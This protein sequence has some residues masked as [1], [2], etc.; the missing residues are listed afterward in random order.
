MENN[1]CGIYR[2]QNYPKINKSNNRC[3]KTKTLALPISGAKFTNQ[4]A[5][6]MTLIKL[7]YM[8]DIIMG[9]SGG[10]VTGAILLAAGI[11]NVK[12]KESYRAFKIK[13]MEI[14][15][16]LD[17]SWYMSHWSTLAPIN[18]IEALR[19]GS[20]YNRGNGSLFVRNMYIDISSQ[21]ELWIGTTI[22]LSRISQ[23]FC[24]KPKH[25]SK[26]KIEGAKYMENN[27]SYLTEATTASC[28]VPTIVPSVK[29]GNHKYVD[30]GVTYASPLGPCSK[31]FEDE[32]ISFH[33]VYI[34]PIRYSSKEDPHDSEIEDDDIWNKLTSSAAGMVTGLHIPDRNNG[35]RSVGPNAKKEIGRGSKFLACCL[36]KQNLSTRSFIEIAPIKSTHVN[37]LSMEKGD[38][39]SAVQEGLSSEFSVRHWYL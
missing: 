35:I 2:S 31:A 25:M 17:C 12:C 36:K 5:I 3:E 32:Q 29:I 28:A 20:L 37:F 8:P 6:S 11:N 14:L 13:I 22:E 18:T 1:Y 10:C 34:S 19:N 15:K 23:L 7:G 21:P 38:A 4:I 27:I 24:S 26:I 33:I 39:V 30:G 16:N 9:T